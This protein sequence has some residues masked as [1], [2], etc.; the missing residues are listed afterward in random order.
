MYPGV[1]ATGSNTFFHLMICPLLHVGQ[2]TAVADDPE[3]IRV[4]KNMET[5]SNVAYHG[6]L[7]RSQEMENYRPGQY[8]GKFDPAGIALGAKY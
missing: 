4:R 3:T 5:I 8:E 6:E 2:Y 7:A 1:L